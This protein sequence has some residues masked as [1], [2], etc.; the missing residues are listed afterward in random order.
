MKEPKLATLEDI[1]HYEYVFL[2][3]GR[4]GEGPNTERAMIATIRYLVR[5]LETSPKPT[6]NDV[7]FWS[8]WYYID[9]ADALKRLKG[10]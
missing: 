6:D 1:A 3:D 2:A 7:D 4:R 10:K 9:R 5:V 8:N